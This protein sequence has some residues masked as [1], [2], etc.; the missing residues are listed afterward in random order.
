MKQALRAAFPLTIPVMLGY[1]FAGMAFGVL[2]QQAGY[3][4]WWAGLMSLTVYAGSMQYIAVTFFTGLSGIGGLLHVALMTLLVNIRHLF[5]GISFLESFRKAGAARWYLIFSLTDETYSLLCGSKVPE[6]I[7]NHKFFLAISLLDQLYW[8]IGSMAGG[9]LG[10]LITFDT[11]GIDFALTAL[12][13]VI[14]TEQ[15]LSATHHAPALIGLGASV[16]AL[17]LF[18]PNQMIVPAMVLIC[19]AL[20]ALRR[21]LGKEEPV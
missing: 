19:A 12:F 18:G 2:F 15:W 14:F 10:T 13:L 5:Y 6:G 9:A 3:S 17:L 4:L 21:T 7:E 16:V 1:L 8:I 11:T 20:M